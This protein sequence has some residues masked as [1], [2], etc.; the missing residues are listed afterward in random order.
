MKLPRYFLFSLLALGLSATNCTAATKPESKADASATETSTSQSKDSAI[1]ITPSGIADIHIGDNINKIPSSIAGLYNK[2]DTSKEINEMEGTELYSTTCSLDGKNVLDIS[3]DIDTGKI[4]LISCLD[5]SLKANING[6]IIS[7]GDPYSKVKKL[8]G[9]TIDDYG[10]VYVDELFF[11]N[12]DDK[13]S[14]IGLG[15]PW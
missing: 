6:T 8:P 1:Y 14:A 11:Y 4:Y 3:A 7:V 10:T 12:E 9:A 15:S 5:N 13:V 2:V